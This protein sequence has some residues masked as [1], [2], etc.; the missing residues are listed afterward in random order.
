[1]MSVP[2]IAT[3]KVTRTLHT[4]A[5]LRPVVSYIQD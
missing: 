4:A 2:R 1:M 5:K 3:T